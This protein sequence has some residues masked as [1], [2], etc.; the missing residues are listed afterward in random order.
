MVRVKAWLRLLSKENI[1]CKGVDIRQAN[2]YGICD[3]ERSGRSLTWPCHARHTL[4]VRENR[5][6]P[7]TMTLSLI[8]P[9][10]PLFCPTSTGAIRGAFILKS[11]DDLNKLSK[12][13]LRQ[14][15]WGW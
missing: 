11:R 10:L 12:A 8:G 13:E 14:G 9:T 7:R 4:Q 2:S 15:G 6:P 1:T 3:F 5:R